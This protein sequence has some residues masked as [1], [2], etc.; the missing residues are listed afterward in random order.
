MLKL[1]NA[2][3]KNLPIKIKTKSKYQPNY[4]RVLVTK[5]L[6]DSTDIKDTEIHFVDFYGA[7]NIVKLWMVED[8][9]VW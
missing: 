3:S 2:V 5:V 8:V 1:E 9:T 6:K 7:K 4:T